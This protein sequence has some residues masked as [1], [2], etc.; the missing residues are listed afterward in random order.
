MWPAPPRRHCPNCV[1]LISSVELL[2]SL[3]GPKM[4]ISIKT[5]PG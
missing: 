5:D 1:Q 3:T 4:S 2:K